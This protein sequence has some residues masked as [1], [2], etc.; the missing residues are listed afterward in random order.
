MLALGCAAT[1][2]ACVLL[3]QPFAEIGIEDDWSYVRS[4]Q[5]LAA[6]G[7]VVYNGWAT[8]MLGWQLWLGALAIKLFG[9]AFLPARCAVLLVAMAA[10]FLLHRLLM[11]VGVTAFNATVGT[12]MLMA[13]PLALPLEIT[14]HTDIPGL[15]CILA[16]MYGCVRAIDAASESRAIAWLLLA[17][18][19]GDL[20]GTAR[21]IAW[22][23]ALVLVPTAV[24]ML[25]RSRRIV[26]AGGLLWLCT[27]AFVFAGMHWFAQQPYAVP[28]KILS[29]SLTVPVA[30]HAARS[31]LLAIFGTPLFLL[32]ALLAFVPRFPYRNARAWLWSGAAL[33]LTGLLYWTKYRKHL[34]DLW[35]QPLTGNIVSPRGL[36]DA[37]AMLASRPLVLHL[38]S[39]SVLTIVC[40]IGVAALIGCTLESSATARL[41]HHKRLLFLF[42]P[43]FA[44][45]CILLLPRAASLYIVDRYLLPLLVLLGMALLLCFQG[46]ERRRLPSISVAATLLFM[47]SGVAGL[48]DLF[49]MERARLQAIAAVRQLGV[50][51]EHIAGGFEY[52]AWT[53]IQA[54]GYLTDPR[55]VKPAGIRLYHPQWITACQN[56]TSYLTPAVQPIYLLS[57]DPTFCRDSSNL[58]PVTFRTW[59]PPFSTTIYI[60]K[61]DAPLDP[62]R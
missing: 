34:L 62:Y 42:G 44:A 12:L 26:L 9:A 17:T 13:S 46:A 32:P 56:D 11:R 8:A 3:S 55:I 38:P 14:F 2:G 47:G 15:F 60:L 1:L 40:A 10:A 39:R 31:V 52:D 5:V 29:G 41:Q 27:L 61:A 25:R 37:S 18:I 54:M 48:H 35:L 7:H 16:A 22:L 30:Q 23:A 58:P 59:L 24:W 50:P 28:E 19:A 49:A 51:R 45:Y 33:A 20:G 4:A 57:F 53:Q 43:F 36:V 6:T 21:Q